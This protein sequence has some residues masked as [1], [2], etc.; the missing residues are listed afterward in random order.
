MPTSPWFS[1]LLT[2]AIPPE[3]EV[4]YSGV[5]NTCSMGEFNFEKA[6]ERAQAA[7]RGESLPK[8][9]IQPKGPKQPPANFDYR[10]AIDRAKAKSKPV[11]LEKLEASL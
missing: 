9:P 7:K 8:P 1:Q 5:N 4:R 6:V 2:A 10:A 3:S 11:D